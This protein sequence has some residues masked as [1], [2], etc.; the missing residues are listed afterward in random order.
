VLELPEYGIEELH[1][2]QSG[3]RWLRSELFVQFFDGG[4]VD[5]IGDYRT[6]LRDGLRE[7]GLFDAVRFI[8]FEPV[9]VDYQESIDLF[10]NASHLNKDGQELLASV[11][12]S[13]VADE[14]DPPTRLAPRRSEYQFVSLP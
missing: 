8:E 11:V 4:K 6:A 7:A 9:A 12:A 3:A 14:F 1:A 5:V 13:A 10:Q 2:T